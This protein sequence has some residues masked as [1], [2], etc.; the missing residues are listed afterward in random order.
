MEKNGADVASLTYTVNF[1]NGFVYVCDSQMKFPP[2]TSWLLTVSQTIDV[3][4]KTIISL[5][6]EKLLKR[7]S[8][9]NLALK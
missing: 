9:S 3:P 4:L 1:L 2:L 7:Y 6:T 8:D 5:Q